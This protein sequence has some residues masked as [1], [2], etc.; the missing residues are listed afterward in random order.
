MPPQM[1]IPT[2][3][4]KEARRG[5][6]LQE[7]QRIAFGQPPQVHIIETDIMSLRLTQVFQQAGL[8]DLP[9]SSEY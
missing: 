4:G 8:A 3:D 5:K 9:W 7:E 2:A 1:S 6:L